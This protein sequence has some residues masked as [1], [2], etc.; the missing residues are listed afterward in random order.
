MKRI[1]RQDWTERGIWTF[2]SSWELPSSLLSPRSPWRTC[3][4]LDTEPVFVMVGWAMGTNAMTQGAG[5]KKKVH[6][7]P[8]S[9]HPMERCAWPGQCWLQH[10]LC[11]GGSSVVGRGPEHPFTL[12]NPELQSGLQP[13]WYEKCSFPAAHQHCFWLEV[14]Q[15]FLLSQL[16]AKFRG[17]TGNK[18]VSLHTSIRIT[19]FLSS[20]EG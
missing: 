14:L 18:L 16:V 5:S 17:R 7:P 13:C 20:F 2:S 12:E 3:V 8:D 19:G 9:H 10:A 6:D 1:W 4:L 11:S 15:D